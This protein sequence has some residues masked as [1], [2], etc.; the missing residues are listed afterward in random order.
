MIRNGFRVSPADYPGPSMGDPRTI[1]KWV[2]AESPAN[3]RWGRAIWVPGK[4]EA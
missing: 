2:G 3:G 4:L 1:G